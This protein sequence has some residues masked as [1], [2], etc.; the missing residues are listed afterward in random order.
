M[1]CFP[2]SWSLRCAEFEVGSW[3]WRELGIWP[4]PGL[5]G[6]LSPDGG[7]VSGQFCSPV[8]ESDVYVLTPQLFQGH[9]LAVCEVRVWKSRDQQQAG[10]PA[11]S[12]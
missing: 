3:A 10:V 1:V 4:C 11:L 5:F 8:K 7:E 2:L 9:S 12:S 6:Q